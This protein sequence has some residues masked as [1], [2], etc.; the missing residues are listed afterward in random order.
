MMLELS[1]PH[2]SDVFDKI[3]FHCVSGAIITYIVDHH[4]THSTG[5]TEL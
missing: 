2:V 4:E 1:A 5:S 3:D